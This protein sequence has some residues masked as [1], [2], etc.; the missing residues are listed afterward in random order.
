MTPFPSEMAATGG[1]RVLVVDDSIAVRSAIRAMLSGLP[2]VAQVETARSAGSALAILQAKARTAPW[3][4]VVLDVEMPAMSG[5]EALPHLL[6]ASPTSRVVM[7]SSLTR[8]GAAATMAALA[9][10]ASDYLC[11]PCASAGWEPSAFATELVTKIGVWGADARRQRMLAAG[12]SAGP[13]WPPAGA[14]LA[15]TSDRPKVHLSRPP[16]RS[17]STAGRSVAGIERPAERPAEEQPVDGVALRNGSLRPFRA[18]AI[19]S[20]TGGP[21]ALMQ[22]F[23]GLAAPLCVPVFVTQHMPPAFTAILA[24]QIGRLTGGGCIEAADGEIVA[25]GRVYVA[26]GDHHLLV[27][28][29]DGER[30]TLRLSRAAPENFCRPAVDPMLCSLARVYRDELCVVILTGMGQ[31][32]LRGCRVV[33]EAGGQVIVQDEATSVVWG[34]P[35]AVAR[36]GLADLI[37]PLPEIARRLR[38]PLCRPAVAGS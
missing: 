33:R 34:M 25:A 9:A 2:Q 16:C 20:S 27:E 37:L 30:P 29:A 21:Q 10:G 1:W 4:V 26:P 22:L 32:G 18:L 38:R 19:G 11:K 31:D 6:Q 17:L 36:G 7:A 23:G 14:P 24:Q 8:R 3:D 28:R 15:T 13:S 12:R 35:G 5:I